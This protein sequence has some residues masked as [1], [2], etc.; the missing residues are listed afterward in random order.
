MMTYEAMLRCIRGNIS[1][2]GFKILL[3]L[4]ASSPQPLRFQELPYQFREPH[5]SVPSRLRIGVADF[6]ACGVDW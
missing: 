2:V 6:G 3:D 5:A 1:G 4:F